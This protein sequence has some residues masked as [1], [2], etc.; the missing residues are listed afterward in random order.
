MEKNSKKVL[1][2]YEKRVI[3]LSRRNRLLKYPKSARSIDF[4]M[5]LEEFQE[6]FGIVQELEIPFVHKDILSAEQEELHA[7]LNEAKQEELLTIEKPSEE[8][9]EQE[10][11]QWIPQTKPEG[12]KLITTLTALRLD[13]KRKFEEHGLH[14]LFITIGKVQWKEPL[15]GRGSTEA[16]AKNEYDYNAPLLLIPVIIEEKKVPKKTVVRIYDEVSDVT[17]NKVLSLLLVKE[18]GARKLIFND[19]L[20]NDLPA[21]VK[22]L[23]KQIKSIFSELH[24]EVTVTEDIQ[25]G[26]YTFYGQQIYED[27]KNNE[28]AMLENAFL[29]ALCTHTP[30]DQ[31]NLSIPIET[32]DNFLSV[33]DDFTV[34]DADSSQLEVIERVMQGSN[35]NIQGPP[36]TGKSQTIV[37]IIANLIAR[38][39]TVLLVCEKQ[40]ALEVVLNRLKEVGLDKLCLPLFKYSTD[41]KTFAKSIIDDR[42]ALTG[43]KQSNYLN[44]ELK[45]REK[46]INDLRDYADA[47]GKNVEPLEKSVFWVHGELAKYKKSVPHAIPWKEEGPLNV[48]YENYRAAKNILKTLE[49]LL[50]VIRDEKHY[51]WRIVNKEQ[52]SSDYFTRVQL[53]LKAV[54][55]RIEV[56]SD[57]HSPMISWNN[58]LEVRSYFEAID[59]ISKQAKIN[60]SIKDEI[61]VDDAIKTITEIT[62]TIEEFIAKEKSFKKSYNLPDNWKDFN[63]ED[64]DKIFSNDIELSQL[65]V[66]NSAFSNSSESLQTAQEVLQSMQAYKPIVD[67]PFS[68]I[69]GN[70]D[71]LSIDS[72]ISILKNWQ[73]ISSIEELAPSLANLELLNNKLLE[74][75]RILIKWG[76]VEETIDLTEA[77]EIFERFNEKY[78]FI[79]RYF[80]SQYKRDVSKIKSWCN[81]K[82]PTG[83]ND[84]KEVAQS[85]NG[86]MQQRDKLS[87][88]VKSFSEKY[89]KKSEVISSN[90]IPQLNEDLK[91]VTSFLNKNGYEELSDDYISYITLNVDLEPKKQLYNTLLKFESEYSTVLKVF[92]E[93]NVN[94]AVTFGKFT[95]DTKDLSDKVMRLGEL[96]LLVQDALTDI[97]DHPKTVKSLVSHVLKMNE[98]I[99][100]RDKFDNL[101][102]GNLLNDPL[103]F[104]EFIKNKD[105]IATALG[106]IK[107]MVNIIKNVHLSTG[108]A[109]TFGDLDNLVKEKVMISDPLQEEYSKLN[110]DLNAMDSLLKTEINLSIDWEQIPLRELKEQLEEMISDEEGLATWMQF[111]KYRRKMD[112]L[113]FEWFIDEMLTESNQKDPESLFAV[114]L[115]QAWLDL[116]YEKSPALKNFTLKDHQRLI[117]EFKELDSKSHKINSL[118]TLQHMAEQ[119]RDAKWKYSILERELI[120][121]SQLKMRHKSVRRLINEIGNQIVQY[122]RCW[123]MS[124]L[125]LSSY[126]PFGTLEFDVVIFDEASQMRVEHA[127]GSI[128]R[129]KQVIIFGDENQLPPTSFFDVT[130]QSDE[131]E[132]EEDYESVLHAT[133]EILPGADRLLSYHYRSKFED[134]IAFS[135]HYIYRDELITFPNPSNSIDP[136]K[137]IYL[138]DGVFDGGKEGTRK[139]FEEAD[140]VAQLCIDHVKE[141]PK[142]SLG[143]I[144]FSKSQEAAIRDS[145]LKLLDKHP[146]CIDLLNEDSDEL[147]KF[148]I[149]NLE[150]VQGDERDVIILSVG[151]G[152]DKL[153]NMYQRFGPINS[154]TGYRRLNVAVTRAKE[155]IICVASIKATDVKSENASRGV[156]L[157]QKYLEYAEYGS[158]TLQASKLVQVQNDV[159][160]DSPFE[161]EV[162]K[163]LQAVGFIV[164]RQVGASGYKIDLAI[165]NPKNEKEYLLGIECDGATYHS[166]YSA[167]MNDRIRQD[168]LE[169]LGWKL[170]RIWSQHWNTHSGAIIDDIIN[171]VS[172]R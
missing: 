132:D 20:L 45:Y 33:K 129:A 18:H 57:I 3:D 80:S 76:I 127:I 117:E 67:M 119:I 160:V 25:I 113:G 98:L 109:I 90:L 31:E 78:N 146:E 54:I 105:E 157:L 116:Y 73:K 156:K 26:Q 145:V 111:L 56:L 63:S 21:L 144:A 14:T 139:N 159:G 118:R 125:T 4:S 12:K 42:N 58:L 149:K 68:K 137:F 27:I 126:I 11:L 37:N 30:I 44:E 120:H 24:I 9:N 163:A 94:E 87:V 2:T 104:K 170:Y 89:V 171:V 16:K 23:T 130:D 72:S 168:N 66:I 36:G 84:F 122:K 6:H 112:E 134:L 164:H 148:F 60:I 48:T 172:D 40:V 152:K 1:E 169:R 35:L 7:I 46:I 75:K 106:N 50:S 85:I 97:K 49:P 101:N 82:I 83:F 100:I 162:E 121:Q 161:E 15:S 93:F 77:Q 133:K 99:M 135:N 32:A 143:V 65:D 41:K 51:H 165:V 62:S 47:L 53:L 91:K 69:V 38:N 124:P 39:K 88:L 70:K 64:Y 140:T 166:S 17:F 131:E 107:S 19:E 108:K 81:A 95:N 92:P 155:K 29:N 115:W 22:D 158:K 123:M 13:T 110:I 138:E 86:F 5:T 141:F 10:E 102:I 136:V 128:A 61:N 74:I 167:R 34:M 153:G 114:T 43:I 154:N 28:D 52:Y 59:E 142:K 150:S 71:L 103:S 8:D 55:S 147:E 79:N 96:S 151:Y